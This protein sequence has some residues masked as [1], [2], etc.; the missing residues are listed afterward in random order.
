MVA[1]QERHLLIFRGID[2]SGRTDLRRDHAGRHCPASCGHFVPVL[3][4]ERA[5]RKSGGRLLRHQ[6]CPYHILT[7]DLENLSSGGKA[8]AKVGV[9]HI[10]DW[11]SRARYSVSKHLLQGAVGKAIHDLLQ[12]T[13][14]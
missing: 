5:Q 2:F 10:R 1:C 8:L 3:E 13:P 14:T 7:S 6:V 12:P 9:A 11:T 4:W